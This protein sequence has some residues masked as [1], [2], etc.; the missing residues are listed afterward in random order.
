[1]SRR[2]GLA[3]AAL[4][5]VLILVIGVIGSGSDPGP[6]LDPDNPRPAGT[7]A[8][9][10][11]LED[12][13]ADVGVSDSDPGGADVVLVLRDRLTEDSHQRL[14]AFSRAGGTLVVA[15]PTS[16]LAN[17]AGRRP[18]GSGN[19]CTIEAWR[20]FR[21]TQVRPPAAPLDPDGQDYCLGTDTGA[22]VTSR[23]EGSGV[24]LSVARPQLFANQYIGQDDNARLAVVLLAPTTDTSVVILDPGYIETPLPGTGD[25]GLWDLIPSNIKWAMLQVAIAFG[26]LVLGVS[27]RHGRPV[28][29]QKAVELASSDLVAATGTLYER[30][31]RPA[32]AA[33]VLQDDLRRIIARRTGLAADAPVADLARA[34]ETRLGVPPSSVQRVLSGGAADEAELLDL[35]H[36]LSRIRQEVLDG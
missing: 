7:K 32:F 11:L 33:G 2:S 9:R 22:V 13:G 19:E 17:G 5:I 1:M 30:A 18:V 34:A 36:D 26:L 23:V 12:L 35:A 29:E 8:L 21:I 15:D 14:L 24:V 10:L 4:V 6:A 20:V 27:R 28:P 31:R 3:L 16:P 25:Q